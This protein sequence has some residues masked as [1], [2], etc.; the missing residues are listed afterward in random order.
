MRQ[1]QNHGF[2]LQSWV[3]V[4]NMAKQKSEEDKPKITK[5]PKNYKDP[6]K[7]APLKL[8]R[9]SYKGV[10]D[11]D[12]LQLFIKQYFISRKYTFQE[13]SNKYKKG[14]PYGKE[15]EAKTTAE[16]QFNEYFKWHINTYAHYFDLREV[17][18]IKDGVKK[19]MTKGKFFIEIDGKLETD[20]QGHFDKSSFTF[21]IKRFID[22][23]ILFRYERMGGVIWD[24]LYYEMLRF[25]NALKKYLDMET[26]D[27]EAYAD[28]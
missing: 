8:S 27:M 23:M 24:K 28:A 12:H 13:K 18:V 19:K 7:K 16:R 10:F 3:L 4:S 25:H 11:Y 22:N 2:Q 15:M 6:F 21:G 9:I 26:A 1:K 14:N 5:T 20:Y 17:E